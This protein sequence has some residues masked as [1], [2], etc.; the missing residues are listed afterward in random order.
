MFIRIGNFMPGPTHLAITQGSGV[1][2]V[3]VDAA[4]EL[5]VGKLRVWAKESKVQPRHI[6]GYWT[7]SKHVGEIGPNAPARPGEKV[8]Y[9]LH[10]GGFI[11]LS[12]HNSSPTYPIITGLLKHI[13]S[14][15]RACALE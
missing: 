1:N 3:W 10:G 5:I 12:A 15:S 4:P 8:L 6:P 13:K 14:I 11:Q 2:G 9:H 7:H